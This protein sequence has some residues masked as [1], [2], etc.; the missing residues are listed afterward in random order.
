MKRPQIKDELIDQAEA[1]KIKFIVEQVDRNQN[2]V[3]LTSEN[4]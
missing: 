3:Y 4:P 1:P 2:K